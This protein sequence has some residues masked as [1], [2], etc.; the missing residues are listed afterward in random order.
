MTGHL[1]CARICFLGGTLIYNPELH[2]VG[3][4]GVDAFLTTDETQISTD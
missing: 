4:R 1:F 3:D 2:P